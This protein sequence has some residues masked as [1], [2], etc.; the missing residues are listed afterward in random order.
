MVKFLILITITSISCSIFA[1][2]NNDKNVTQ[3]LDELIQIPSKRDLELKCLT[4]YQPA[5]TYSLTSNMI[6]KLNGITT[7]VMGVGIVVGC[8]VAATSLPESEKYALY[9]QLLTMFLSHHPE[10][11]QA[12][13]TKFEF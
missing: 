8:A 12:L 4:I 1:M 5:G 9:D 6:E 3:I 10:K 7:S 11:L 2:D 13:K